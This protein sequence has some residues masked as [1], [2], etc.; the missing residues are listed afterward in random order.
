LRPQI[1]NYELQ[2]DNPRGKK[3]AL[4]IS[5]FERLVKPSTGNFQVPL[6]T[7]KTQ[8]RMHPS[9]SELVRVP[10]YPDLQ[11][12]PSVSEYPEVEGMRD[13]LYWLDHQAK[14]DAQNAQAISSSKTNSFE[15]EMVAAL[16]SHLV[17]QGT[18]GHEDIAVLTPYLGQLQK[19]RRRLASDF[20]IVVG[21]RDEEDLVA[22]GIEDDATGV[23]TDLRVP[24]QKTTLLN[25]LRIATVDNFQ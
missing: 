6:N 4:D 18:Y 15:V 22:K 19:L 23:T 16:V 1:N 21:D 9:I 5:L 3:F 14:E 7:L 17:K 12:H 2:H 11:D 10:L 25:A 20:V 13:R 24:V 8:R